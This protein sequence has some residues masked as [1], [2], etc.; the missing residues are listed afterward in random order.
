[1]IKLILYFRTIRYLKVKQVFYLIYYKFFKPY[2]KI[3]DAKLKPINFYNTKLN[4]ISS[5]FILIKKSNIE[6]NFLN[7]KKSFHKYSIN[8]NYDSFGKLW[9]YN[10]N[11]FDFISEFNVD[12]ASELLKSYFSQLHNLKCGLESYPTSLR[13]INLI[14]YSLINNF[15]SSD[16]IQILKSDYKRLSKRLEIHIQANHLLENYFALYFASIYFNEIKFKKKITRLLISEI[17]EQFDINGFHYENSFMYHSILLNRLI[18]IYTL[19]IEKNI[20]DKKFINLLK[21]TILKGMNVMNEFDVNGKLPNFND[22]NSEG[23]ISLKKLINKLKGFNEFTS[24][25]TKFIPINYF[26]LINKNFKVFADYAN[27]SPTYQPSHSHADTFNF[28][29]YFKNKSIVVDPGVSTYEKNDLRELQRSTLYHNTITYDNHNSS[30]VWGGFR[31]G[32]RAN[33]LNLK[34]KPNKVSASHDGYK[35]L[36]C[37]HK[38]EINLNN[39]SLIISDF[40]KEIKN[41]NKIS[42]IHFSPY[43]KI[44]TFSNYLKINNEIIFSWRGIIKWEIKN[45]DFSVGFNNTIKAKCWEGVVE[46]KSKL[47]FKN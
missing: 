12:E 38:R 1:M 14:K 44:N 23:I 29:Y 9:T 4:F 3:N 28:I 42:R 30:E 39:D 31:C 11:Y 37:Y 19:S 33:I 13:I 2:F 5:N 35:H 16:L 24:Y 8:W 17:N 10:L 36:D 18:D 6:F 26:K 21:N 46:N 15:Y 41:R 22:S 40:I 47:I 43:V 45:Y 25:K 7:K 27:I 20:N 34:S 32:K